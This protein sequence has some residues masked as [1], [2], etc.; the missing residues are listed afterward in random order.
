MQLKHTI[1]FLGVDS[2]EDDDD[3]EERGETSLSQVMRL[4]KDMIST[5]AKSTTSTKR[6][7]YLEGGNYASISA[8]ARR[9]G[10]NMSVLSV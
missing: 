4:R 9:V 10:D 6:N 7:D 2:I 5:D 3:E 1:C 8:A